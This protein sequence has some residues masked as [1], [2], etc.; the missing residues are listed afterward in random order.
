MKMLKLLFLISLVSL[1]SFGQIDS[2]KSEKNVLTDQNGTVEKAK[3]NITYIGTNIGMA[4]PLGDF[5]NQT[6]SNPKA[7]LASGGLS[8]SLVNFGA[9]FGGKFG[10]HIRYF[11]N[12]HAMKSGVNQ[13]WGY[14][15]IMVGP[16]YTF[17]VF[18]NAYVDIKPSIG[19][20]SSLIQANKETI[21][22]GSGL[23][24]GL[25]S[26]FRYNFARKWA[27]TFNLD[28]STTSQ[29]MKSVNNG[30]GNPYTQSIAAFSTNLG[31]I[32]YFKAP[33]YK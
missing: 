6:L 2:S 16:S 10:L 29:N 11:A 1:N 32:Y 19:L 5:G 23:G 21:R 3:N 31:A 7:G 12:A 27:V 9:I 17:D 14:G 15:S 30:V 22:E 28:Y 18:K 4:I 25:G 26:Q 24:L 13:A 33:V 8:F 20:M